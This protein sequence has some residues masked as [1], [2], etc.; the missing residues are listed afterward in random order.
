[1]SADNTPPQTGQEARRGLCRHTCP[2][3]AASFANRHPRQIFCSDRHKRAWETRSAT[4]ARQLFPHAAA[5][6]LTRD[7]SRGDRETGRKA[8]ILAAQLIQAW[9]DDDAAAGRMSAVDYAAV[10]YRLGYDLT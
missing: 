7:G 6:R 1:M 10:R 3:C 8:S 4:R 9:R 5:A 2:E